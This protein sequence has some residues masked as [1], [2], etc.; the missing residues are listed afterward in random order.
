MTLNAMSIVGSS[1]LKW[2]FMYIGW[3]FSVKNIYLT[4][5]LNKF[6]RFLSIFPTY[7]FFSLSDS[8][9][10]SLSESLSHYLFVLPS[11]SFPKCNQNPLQSNKWFYHR[12]K[13]SLIF[14]TQPQIFSTALSYPFHNI[15]QI[16]N[17]H[18]LWMYCCSLIPLLHPSS[19]LAW[20]STT[21]ASRFCY[22]QYHHQ[23]HQIYLLY[24]FVF[25]RT[26]FWAS[27]RWLCV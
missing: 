10:H 9:S 13:M 1:I 11:L 17:L 22:M 26:F 24:S 18:P 2:N 21:K 4:L 16:Q 8:L 25:G 27:L 3:W 23:N 6:S 19:T 5:L 15:F 14:F 20:D 7:L 12:L